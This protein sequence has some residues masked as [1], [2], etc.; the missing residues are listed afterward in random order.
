MFHFLNQLLLTYKKEKEGKK[1]SHYFETDFYN[2]ALCHFGP[3][4]SKCDLKYRE[5]V[6]KK[7]YALISAMSK[8]T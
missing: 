7:S 1:S 8:R 3:A 5:N 6:C 2:P 4:F